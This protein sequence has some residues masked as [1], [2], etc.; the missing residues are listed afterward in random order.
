LHQ[1]DKVPVSSELLD[2]INAYI[3]SLKKLSAPILDHSEWTVTA[4][5]NV[6]LLND[7]T[8]LYRYTDVT[9]QAEFIYH[10]IEKFVTHRLP[11]ELEYLRVFDEAKRIIDEHHGMPDKDLTLLVNLC[12]QNGGRLSKNKRK[13]FEMLS[14]DDVA[15]ADQV[16]GEVF[17]DYFEMKSTAD[18]K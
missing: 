18:G 9:E 4:D 6:K 11:Q 8:E 13:L 3:D 5:Y 1:L 17:A 15:F 10:C 2:Q 7:T 12:V 14:D 16:I